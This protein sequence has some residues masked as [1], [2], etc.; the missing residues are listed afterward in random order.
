MCVSAPPGGVTGS[1]CVP[2]SD[3]L[4]HR[5]TFL[6]V[7]QPGAAALDVPPAS[8]HLLQVRQSHDAQIS[9]YHGNFHRALLPGLTVLRPDETVA[10]LLR[11][12]PE[13]EAR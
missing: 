13:A 8:D 6:R 11:W 1:F 2:G 5:P 3:L 7:P 10:L 9:C 4:P 12:P